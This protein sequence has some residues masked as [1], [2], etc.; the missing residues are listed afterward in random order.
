MNKEII[1]KKYIGA[2]KSNIDLLKEQFINSAK[3]NLVVGDTGLGKTV[4][5]ILA[6]KEL[7]ESNL[8]IFLVP[9]RN[10][11]IQLEHDFKHKSVVGGITYQDIQKEIGKGERI[12][13]VV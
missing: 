7:P 1:V 6:M 4:A 5:F 3:D 10:Q 12:F 11:A 9:N 8:N 2:E 13:F